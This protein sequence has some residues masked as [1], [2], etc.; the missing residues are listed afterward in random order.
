MSR[1]PREQ[2]SRQSAFPKRYGAHWDEDGADQPTMNRA[3]VVTGILAATFLAGCDAPASN[4]GS[5]TPAPAATPSSAAA[6]TPTAVPVSA[7]FHALACTAM[8][9][10]GQGE[11]AASEMHWISAETAASP[12]LQATFAFL[13]LGEDA[14]NIALDQHMKKPTLASDLATYHTDLDTYSGYVAN[15]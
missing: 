7:P 5:A 1:I 12:D 10:A 14:A 9:L 13:Q 4:P 15:C 11:W 8:Q 6:P 2:G 3:L